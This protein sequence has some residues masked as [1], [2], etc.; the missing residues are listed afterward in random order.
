M[1]DKR[2]A[3]EPLDCY[4]PFGLKNRLAMA[5]MTRCQCDSLGRPSEQLGE[6]YVARARGGVGLIIVESC[7]VNASD[8]LAYANGC[9]MN[10]Q[11]HVEAWRPI[12]DSIHETGAKA[13]VQLFHGGR[14]TVP[15]ICGCTPIAPSA[16]KPGGERSFW[17]PEVDGQLVHFQTRTPF[18]T[19]RE[20][21]SE[22]IDRIVEDFATACRLALAA[23]FDGVELHGAHGYLIHEFCS[24]YTNTRN[25]VYGF[26]NKFFFAS[27][28]VKACRREIPLDI[29][30]SYRLSTHMI[31]NYYLSISNMT[32]EHLIPLLD[33]TGI[34]VFHS[35]ELRVGIPVDRSGYSLGMAIRLHTSKPIIG[36]GGIK[37]LDDIKMIMRDSSIYDLF[38][39]GRALITTT[40]I[41]EKPDGQ[42]FEY[43]KHYYHLKY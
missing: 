6:Y 36:C 20:M 37:C 43:E 3:P 34:D 22:D 4:E 31:D 30:L 17:R 16:I 19:P 26:N 7:A 23:G 5:P 27:E 24:K 33:R 9:Q 40:E 28:I 29:P 42:V 2:H 13:W 21:H 18:Q 15:E 32:L 10:Q 25:D 8:A 14:L 12:V 35:S 38:A 1:S 41:S 11:M 39:V